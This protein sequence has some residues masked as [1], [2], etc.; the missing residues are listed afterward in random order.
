MIYDSN[1][2]MTFTIKNVYQTELGR[3]SYVE[4]PNEKEVSDSINSLMAYV[5]EIIEIDR[6]NGHKLDN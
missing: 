6:A 4:I 2:V 3:L 1:G 5:K